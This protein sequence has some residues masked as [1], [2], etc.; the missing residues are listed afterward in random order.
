M[1]SRRLCVPMA[2]SACSNTSAGVH[3]GDI[4]ALPCSDTYTYDIEFPSGFYNGQWLQLM[5]AGLCYCLIR[6]WRHQSTLH[7]VPQST[8]P[9]VRLVHT[10]RDQSRWESWGDSGGGVT[11][12]YNS[13]T[14]FYLL[15][16]VSEYG[17]SCV[18]QRDSV[19]WSLRWNLSHSPTLIF[20]VNLS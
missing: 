5:Q 19:L 8:A 11:S 14:G 6:S 9:E 15:C 17:A 2:T 3:C 10:V 13:T 20:C 16:Y 7:E 12:S 1:E 18:S 4:M